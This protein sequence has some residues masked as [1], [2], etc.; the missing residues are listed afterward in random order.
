MNIS[1]KIEFENLHTLAK[2]NIQLNKSDWHYLVTLI[3][4][5]SCYWV[6][7]FVIINTCII[8]LVYY[9]LFY[10]VHYACRSKYCFRTSTDC[11]TSHWR[12]HSAAK[13]NA[14]KQ[15]V[16][17]GDYQEQTCY[18][19][20]GDVAQKNSYSSGLEVNL[21][22]DFYLQQTSCCQIYIFNIWK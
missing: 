9:I 10:L 16:F 14:W 17:L 11:F 12:T 2:Y 4:F 1:F 8:S 18:A 19:N 13:I 15:R 7:C 22:C 6:K 5:C 20:C 21:N 3:A